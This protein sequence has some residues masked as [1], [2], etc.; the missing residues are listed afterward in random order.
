M[1]EI[2]LTVFI[3]FIIIAGGCTTH[4]DPVIA[5]VNNRPIML[6][7][8]IDRYRDFLSFTEAPDNLR[9]REIYLQSMIDEQ[10]LIDYAKDSGIFQDSVHTRKINRIHDQLLLNYLYQQEI[11]DKIEITEPEL[12]QL[13]AWSKTAL[14]VR[15]LFAKDSAT[16]QHIEQRLYSGESWESLAAEYFEDPVLSTNGGDI[17]YFH[18]GD[19]DPAFENVAFQL[20]DSEISVP[21]RTRYGYSIIQVLDR[22]IDP[23]LTEDEYQQKRGWLKL[24]AF[25]YKKLPSI[26]KYTDRILAGLNI[27]FFENNLTQILNA[28]DPVGYPISER[29]NELPCLTFNQERDVWT[30]KEA[31]KKIEGVSDRQIAHLNSVP[32]LKDILKGII[33]RETLL[34]KARQLNLDGTEEFIHDYNTLNR[35]YVVKQMVETVYN[36]VNVTTATEDHSSAQRNAFIRFRDSLKS[37]ADIS[38]DESILKEFKLINAI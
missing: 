23:F 7:D 21:V 11:R 17:G 27:Q 8:Y 18:L 28:F 31:L 5:S 20:N 30:V 38:I 37:A 33:A 4:S 25:D 34:Q 3:L 22:N 16:I 1:K 2:K 12:R 10:L 13:Y 15:H 35:N 6:S 36:S 26:R 29:N 24:T 19:M 9:F 14:H 32:N